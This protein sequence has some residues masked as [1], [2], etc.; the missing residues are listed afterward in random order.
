MS[1][2]PDA[3][4]A[5]FNADRAAFEAELAKLTRED[6]EYQ[7]LSRAAQAV[8]DGSYSSPQFLA[9]DARRDELITIAADRVEELVRKEFAAREGGEA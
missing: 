5:A 2:Q 7:R 3:L 6:A 9:M 8:E 4:T 1:T